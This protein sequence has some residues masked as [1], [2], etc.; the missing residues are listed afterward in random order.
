LELQ[1]KGNVL[2]GRKRHEV[3]GTIFTIPELT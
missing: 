3:Q 2:R 1:E